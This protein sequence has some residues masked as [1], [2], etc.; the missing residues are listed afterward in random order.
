MTGMPRK[1]P[2]APTSGLARWLRLLGA[3]FAVWAVVLAGMAVAD[4]LRTRTA[5]AATAADRSATATPTGTTLPTGQRPRTLCDRAAT[6]LH[7][8]GQALSAGNRTAFGAT[9]KDPE[10]AFG[11]AELARFDIMKALQVTVTYGTGIDSGPAAVDCHVMASYTLRGFD[12]QPRRALVSFGVS[13]PTAA[14]PDGLITSRS[15]DPQPWDLAGVRF[16]RTAHTLVI[17]NVSR[18]TLTQ[19]GN[20]GDEAHRAVAAAWGSCP[21]AVLVLPATDDEFL[22]VSGLPKYWSENVGG[23]TEPSDTQDGGNTRIFLRAAE[24]PDMGPLSRLELVTHEITHL[25]TVSQ[26]DRPDVPK[27]L[28]EGYAEWLAM[29]HIGVGLSSGAPSLMTAIRSGKAPREFPTDDDYS[30]ALSDPE[31]AYG[32]GWSAV[33]YIADTYG[34]AKTT[35]LFRDCLASP[36]GSCAT[37][38]RKV[39]GIGLPDLQSRWH[40]WLVRGRL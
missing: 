24:L 36:D 32:S 30:F 5:D 37:S 17:G 38:T 21:G 22:A 27:W 3:G 16:V 12:S 13:Q 19:F 29:R 34:A 39:L 33:K 15:E 20:L 8:Q 25:A 1:S 11:K 9:I 23:V 40:A 28:S 4:G 14:N 35:A 18:P 6:L 26:E 10:S 2:K 31:L 7:N